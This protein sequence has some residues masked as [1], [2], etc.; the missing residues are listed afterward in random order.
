MGRDEQPALQLFYHIQRFKLCRNIIEKGDMIFFKDIFPKHA[1][2]HKI[3]IIGRFHADHVPEMPRQAEIFHARRQKRIGDILPLGGGCHEEFIPQLLE[4]IAAVKEGWLKHR[5]L[6]NRQFHGCGIDGA[7][8]PILQQSIAAVMVGV[9]MGVDDCG[10]LPALCI[11]NFLDFSAG[12]LIVSA[13]DQPDIVIT[14]AINADFG[15]SIDVIGIFCD[16]H[17]FI[18]GQNLLC[19]CF[20]GTLSHALQ[21]DN[22]LDLICKNC[23]FARNY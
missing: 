5:V 16:L 1:V 13:V 19:F 3:N 6:H 10:Q 4:G 7:V 21:G 11:Q 17:Q 12:I 14:Y 18:H 15:R 8:K 9:G 22:P 2:C 20:C 23:V